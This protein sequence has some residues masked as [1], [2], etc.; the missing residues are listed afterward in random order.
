[1]GA[2][3]IVGSWR[4]SW[5]GR[6]FTRAPKWTL[7]IDAAQ[8]VASA[9]NGGF[10]IPLLEARRIDFVQDRRWW[11]LTLDGE[12]QSGLTGLS[13]KSVAA[14]RVA[15][16][17]TFAHRDADAALARIKSWS[18]GVQA[19]FGE[20][21]VA[22]RWFTE[23][24]IVGWDQLRE[25]AVTGGLSA[26]AQR[27]LAA[28]V[29]GAPWDAVRSTTFVRE[30]A[31][32]QNAALVDA[33]LVAEQRFFDR[34]EKTPLTEEQARAVVCFDNR[35]QLVASAGSGKTSTI[36]AKAGW[37]IRKGIARPDEILLLAFNR[38]AADE[39]GERL[40]AR[41]AAAGVPTDG[42]R[43]Q[44]FHAFGLEVIG[45]ATG[46]KPRLAPGL[47]Q[48]NGIGML[49][50][51]VASL[52]ASSREFAAKWWLMQHVLGVPL[53]GDEE[54]E[55]DSWD[56]DARRNGFRT[57]DGQV[58]KSAGER[59]IANWLIQSGVEVEYERPYEIDV[60]DAK[61]S[62]YRP[63]FYYP[64][65]GAYHE[66]WAFVDGDRVPPSF[67]GYLDSRTWKRA[68]HARH[69]TA[70]LETTAQQFSDGTLLDSLDAQLRAQGIT[71]DFDPDRRGA[72]EPLLADVDLLKL[73][74]TFMTHAKS[75]RLADT[76]LRARVR[77][78]AGGRP[79][80]RE[81]VFLDLY[82]AVR[83]EWD[84]RLQTAGEIDFEDMLGL[85]ADA[86]ESGAWASPYR[87][88][89][90]D[91]F[92]DASRARSRM[93]NALVAA[94]GR[95]LFAVGDDWQSIYRFAGSDI[96]SMTRFEA[97]F[98]RGQVLKLE[99]T[100]RNSQELS[101]IAGDFVMRNPA[102]L[103]KTVRSVKSN[104]APIS[105]R[106][107]ASDAET[108]AVIE[109]QVRAVAAG[110]GPG[111][112]A[113]VKVLGRYRSG[114]DLMP[115]R[116]FDGVELSFQTIHSSK[117]LEADH[118]IIVGLDRG[119]F[120][121]VKEDDPLLR[122][123]M[124]EDDPYPFAEERRLFYVALTR[125]RG[126]VVLVTRRGRESPFIAELLESGVLDPVE[127]DE[128]APSP[129]IVCPSCG[130]GVM[131]ERTGPYGAFLACNRFPA[132]TAKMKIGGQ[133][134]SA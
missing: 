108:T 20:A 21:W 63:D 76:D 28:K 119:G 52:K 24:A 97:T 19:A 127:A 96:T 117:G 131:V 53:D 30:R 79:N 101:T 35:V 18:D 17:M 91:E 54:P 39:I 93:V 94:P 9:P 85:A 71:P 15:I 48:D 130:M 100:F 23:E 80:W 114:A 61:H 124:P 81:T 6:L 25:A 36:V 7:R 86:I 106:Q 82:A 105:L 45:A 65:A 42:V 37:T 102:Q 107:V 58:L 75:N 13:G 64:A 46:R 57:L 29:E 3:V 31:R 126:S 77:R 92:Q 87:V 51:I 109:E 72:G 62:Q 22:R 4:P 12:S 112:T 68:L 26:P 41:L 115:R 133:S 34:I 69:G 88:V 38:A 40:D 132:C 134:R 89:L 99:Q 98:G 66:H 5:W 84:R 55:A 74:R 32:T 1:V 67:A 90:V 2:E 122:L 47:E 50:T 103:K 43:A 11:W 111:R 104:P 16:A 27:L 123:A 78:V 70:L 95:F 44:T 59:A 110:L 116:R 113:T 121:S 56:R 14:Y 118:I 83:A 8:V 60:A 33:E 128:D 49:G 120:P 129:A 125:A 10:S 73:L